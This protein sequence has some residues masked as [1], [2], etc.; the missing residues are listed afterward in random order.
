MPAAW[1]RLGEDTDRGTQNRE[2][3]NPGPRSRPHPDASGA[4]NE[5]WELKHTADLTVQNA[6]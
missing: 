6:D 1:A 5:G 3:S 2:E 4:W